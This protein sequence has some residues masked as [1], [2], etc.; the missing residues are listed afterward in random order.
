MVGLAA[1]EASIEVILEAPMAE[2]RRK[3][4][5]LSELFIELVDRQCTGF[6]L[7]LVGC[8]HAWSGQPGARLGGDGNLRACWRH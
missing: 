6:G 4:M 7:E 1:L 2:I 3:S 8:R 5:A